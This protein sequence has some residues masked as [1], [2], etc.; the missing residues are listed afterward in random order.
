MS[1]VTRSR[2][3]ERILVNTLKVV[4][5]TADTKNMTKTARRALQTLVAGFAAAA[6][7]VLVAPGAAQAQDSCGFADDSVPGG[8]VATDCPSDGTVQ[9]QLPSERLGSYRC[10]DGSQVLVSVDPDVCGDP[11]QLTDP[12][13]RQDEESYG[14]H[15]QFAPETPA[16]QQTA[17]APSTPA[18]A[19][20][21][22]A[23]PTTFQA[24]MAD[25]AIPGV[26]QPEPMTYAELV[27]LVTDAVKRVAASVTF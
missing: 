9:D 13:F 17:P 6:T 10:E 21:T 3:L 4:D 16:L 11:R 19:S 12:N 7:L 25:G 14:P 2:G 18:T 5:K 23:D 8:W 24:P 20:A 15:P 22:A 1:G 27:A 26:N